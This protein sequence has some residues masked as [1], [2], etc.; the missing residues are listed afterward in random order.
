M[1]TAQLSFAEHRSGSD[2]CAW[3]EVTWPKVTLGPVRGYVL[4]MRHRKLRNIRRNRDFSTEVTSVMW[5]VTCHKYVLRM[6]NRKL[7]NIRLHRKWRQSRDRKRPCPE[8]DHVRMRNRKLRNR[9]PRFF[10]CSTSTMDTEGCAH[11][12]PEVAQ[13]F[14][15]FFLTILVGVFS[16]TPASSPGYPGYLSL[17]RHFHIIECICCVVLSTLLRVHLITQ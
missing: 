1:G 16:T 13:R 12:Q 14:P 9:F 11:A 17:S 2:H 15:R 10:Y 5:P 3:P 6:R 8:S 4:R 7:R